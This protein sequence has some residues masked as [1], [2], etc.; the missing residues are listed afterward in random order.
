MDTIFALAT[1]PGRSGV[2]VIRISGSN[3]TDSLSHFGCM[4][5]P[6]PRKAMYHRFRCGADIIDRGLLLYFPA[7]KSF[8]GEDCIEFQLHG[9]V[10]V[11]RKVLAE[12]GTLPSFRLAQPGEFA[13]RAFDNNKLDLTAAEGL[14]DL[15]DAETELQRRQANRFIEGAAARFYD[16]LRAAILEP[17]ALLEATID[18][19]EEDIPP[20]LPL[21][22]AALVSG[23][24]SQIHHQLDAA[25]HTEKLREG[26]NVVLLGAPNAGKSTLINAL[27]RRDVAIVSDIAG[28]TR[29]TIEAHL[30][31]SGLPVILIDTAG[32]RE[33]N[34]GIESQGIAR[35]LARA[36]NADLKLVLFDSTLPPDA[37]SL[38]LIDDTTITVL[39]KKD[40]P[41]GVDWSNV[42]SGKQPLEIAASDASSITL[43][44]TAIA[45]RL[46]SGASSAE[47]GYVFRQRHREHLTAALRSLSGYAAESALDLQCEYLRLAA[48]EIG[49]ITGRIQVDELLG[50]IF[51]RFCI[52]K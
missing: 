4:T 16:Q 7:P 1:P 42:F 28:T 14:A 45:E 43:L 19:A 5:L 48:G 15:I 13:R 3:A 12:L 34:D 33:T 30:D 2:A 10:A 50:H 46:S 27:S 9:S 39:T 35:A 11:I 24:E 26:Y 49:K 25:R 8:T 20:S 6:E 44:L 31:L 22:V 17:L 21:E 23:V 36:E 40:A 29:D 32:I 37:A 52:G 47:P 18:F 38:A 51:S 41:S